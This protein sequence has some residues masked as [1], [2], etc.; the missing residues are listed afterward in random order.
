MLG[1]SGFCMGVGS[2][3]NRHHGPLA[4]LLNEY[5]ERTE[6]MFLGT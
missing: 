1:L 4:Q 3:D 6:T 2:V 5:A